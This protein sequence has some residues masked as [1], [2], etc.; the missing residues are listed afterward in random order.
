VIYTVNIGAPSWLT[1]DPGDDDTRPK[2]LQPEQGRVW[3]QGGR[4]PGRFTHPDLRH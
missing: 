2:P 1:D 4:T 3:P